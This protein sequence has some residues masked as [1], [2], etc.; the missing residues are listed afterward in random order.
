[1][2]NITK[3][4]FVCLICNNILKDPIHLPCYCTIC[5]KHLTDG[6]VKNGLIK[7]E[8]CK[9]NF[10]VKDIEIIENNFAKIVLDA[11]LHLSN[12]EKLMK[13]DIHVLFNKLQNLKDEFSQNK[14]VELNCHE[15]FSELKRQIDVR[16]EEL[17]AK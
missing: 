16:R 6:S 13:R 14:E 15:H 4:D 7:C 12:C 17:K 2:D 9:K 10:L 11:E 8:K 1:M 3:A 5:H